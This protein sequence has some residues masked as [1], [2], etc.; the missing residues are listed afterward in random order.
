MLHGLPILRPYSMSIRRH[1]TYNVVG[2][3]VP[4][5]VSLVTVPLYL[6]TVGLDRY[7]VLNLCWLLV[8]YFVLFDFGLGRATA[9]Q[10]ARL[11]DANP[12]TRSRA[13]WTGITLSVGLAV[14]AAAAALPLIILAVGTLKLD[15]LVRT[16]TQ[17]AIPLLVLAVPIAVLQSV[18]RGALEGRRRFF[19]TNAITSSGA[20]ATGILPLVGAMLWGP[21]LPLLIAIS[22]A[23]RLLVLA[24]FMIA[25][26]RRVPVRAYAVPDRA[27]MVRMVRFG[28]WLTV[29]NIVSPLMSF[30]DRFLI[31]AMIGS[32]A[33]GLYVIPFNLVAQLGI[34]PAAL[35][36]ALYP[37]L[38]AAETDAARSI[39]RS[40]LD[41]LSFVMTPFTLIALFL[42][43]PF[44]Q[45]WIGSTAAAE[46]TPVALVLLF[47]FWV[48]SLAQLPYSRL[49][50]AGRTDV[51]A[52]IHLAEC[53]PYVAA[54]WLGMKHFGIVGAAMAWSVRCTADFLALAVYD[55]IGTS[56]LLSAASRGA[57]IAAVIAVLLMPDFTSNHLMVLGLIVLFAVSQLFR[58]VPPEVYF[59]VQKG[60]LLL[61][62]RRKG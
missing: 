17:A 39:S 60:P 51:I 52:K 27:G 25:A 32:A 40:K 45:L 34:V 16:E 59:K 50:A 53:V 38:A 9:Q 3:L 7:G 30:V 5:M 58:N 12:D 54:L 44:L 37:Q 36:A 20:V 10:I 31:G 21:A 18:L 13:F 48:N 43:G 19:A 41:F 24:A 14:L 57:A 61:L 28:A 1:T 11:H 62:R 56:L 23:V 15:A 55:R 29:T 46:A 2:A 33:V 35:A 22:L 47:G 49:Q 26:V 4:I 6:E 42:V 8:G